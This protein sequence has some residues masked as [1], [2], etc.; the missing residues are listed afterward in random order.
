M[1]TRGRVG[2]GLERK[3]KVFF[4]GGLVNPS[5]KDRN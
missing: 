4:A 2:F 5:R 3:K 1:K